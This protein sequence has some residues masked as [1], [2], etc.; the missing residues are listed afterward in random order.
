MNLNQIQMMQ[1]LKQQFDRF[2]MDH[3]KFPAFV[4]FIGQNAIE[5]GSV[6][7][8]SVTKPSGEKYTSNLKLN[9]ADMEMLQMLRTMNPQG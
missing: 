1:Q 6:I 4:N 3:P 5:E 8:I 9:A 7:E 2:Q